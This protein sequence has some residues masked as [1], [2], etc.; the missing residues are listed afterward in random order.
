MPDILLIYDASDVVAVDKLADAIMQEGITVTRLA[1]TVETV[2]GPDYLLREIKNVRAVV[3]VWSPRSV[4]SQVVSRCAELALGEGKLVPLRTHDLDPTGRLTTFGKLHM[5]LVDD[6]NA[7]GEAISSKFDEHPKNVMFALSPKTKAA[8][9]S[10]LEMQAPTP[11]AAT[12][13]ASVAAAAA[14][15][16][17]AAAAKAV[18][19]APVSPVAAAPPAPTPLAPIQAAPVPAAPAPPVAAAPPASPA[20]VA[21]PPPPPRPRTEGIGAAAPPLRPRVEGVGAASDGI[22]RHEQAWRF[23]L[24]KPGTSIRF[25]TRVA[26]TPRP[27]SLTVDVM[28]Q[29]RGTT[30]G[31]PGR[32]AEARAAAMPRGGHELRHMGRLMPPEE[33]IAAAREGSGSRWIFGLALGAVTAGFVYLFRDTLVQNADRLLAILGLAKGT[34]PVLPSLAPHPEIIVDDVD[35][36][37]FAPPTARGGAKVMVQVFLHGIEQAERA[38]FLAQ[39]MDDAARL[40]GIETL[41]VPIPR[42][43]TVQIDLDGRGLGVTEPV[44]FLLWNGQPT[45]ASFEV[46]VPLGFKGDVCHPVARMTIDGEP[47]GRILFQIRIEPATRDATPLPGPELSGTGATHYTSA[48]LS[49]SSKDRAEVLKRAQAFQAAKLE[50]FQDVLSLEPGQRYSEEILHR[51]GKSDLFVL[52]WSRNAMRSPWVQK[53]IDHALACQRDDPSGLPDIV[54]IMLEPIAKAP[55]PPGLLHL[56]MNAPINTL[57]AAEQPSL[58]RRMMEKLFG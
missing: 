26:P 55:P 56:H 36:S 18:A 27:P 10:A 34:M 31:D 29:A 25:D 46:E 1:P 51:I 54:P 24:D 49:Y 21:P 4:A 35:C 45:V 47:V 43:T 6:W 7:I 15:T 28:Q 22:S 57:I 12:P 50:F 3:V 58:L 39:T 42:R 19:A 40:R 23:Q 2:S 53:E 11:A 44:R 8:S 14:A 20:A 52:F 30:V 41:Q 9:E 33:P 5:P 38:Q 32:L 17:L 48:F 37:V 13:S 16:A